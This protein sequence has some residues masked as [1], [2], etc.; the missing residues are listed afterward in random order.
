MLEP[1]ASVRPSPEILNGK[2]LSCRPASNSFGNLNAL[3][4]RQR[5]GQ[6]KN[7]AWTHGQIA[8]DEL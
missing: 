8:R 6:R 4:I 5:D 3:L 1:D 7:F 2:L